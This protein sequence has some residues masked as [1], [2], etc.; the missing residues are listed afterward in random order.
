MFGLKQKTLEP[1]KAVTKP[2]ASRAETMKESALQE[3]EKI[4][5]AAGYQSHD[6]TIQKFKTF[7]ETNDIPTFNLQEVIKYMDHKATI[8]GKNRWGWKT[9]LEDQYSALGKRRGSWNDE[10]CNFGS[11][12]SNS[13]EHNNGR[14]KRAVPIHALK[15]VIAIRKVFPEEIMF[16]V[17]DS[18]LQPESI[19]RGPDPFLMAIVPNPEIKR[20]VGQFVV[21]FWDEPGFGLEQQLA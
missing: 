16:L 9:L 19:D 17:S 4:A 20:G 18:D 6:F 2:T 5:I 10:N 7:L 15:K 12:R 1:I 8:E 3:Y 14:Y 21:D 11:G 13:Y